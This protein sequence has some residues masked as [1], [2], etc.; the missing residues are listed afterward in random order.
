M[1][2]LL[3]FVVMCWMLV[4]LVQVDLCGIC[5]DV[6]LVIVYCVGIED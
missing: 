6:Y 5:I 1:L 3:G 4:G 2:C